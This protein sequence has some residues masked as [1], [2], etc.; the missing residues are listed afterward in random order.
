M[1]YI[2]SFFRMNSISLSEIE[3]QLLFFSRESIKHLAL[4]SKCGIPISQKILKKNFS[5]NDY[6]IIK[7]LN[8]IM[9]IYKKAKPNIYYSKHS[10]TWDDTTFKKELLVSS[11]ALM[12]LSI[13]KLATHYKNFKNIDDSLFELSKTYTKIA[14]IQLD[15]YYENLRNSEGFFVNKKSLSISNNSYPDLS[16]K[17]ATFSFSDQGYMMLAYYMYSKI[18]EDIKEAETFRSFSLE[19]LEMFD[20][21]K[22]FLYEESF[23]ECSQICYTLNIMYSISKNPKCKN[24][25]LDMSDFILSNYLDYGVSEKDISITTLTSL[26]LYLAY[27]NTNLLVFKEAFSDMCRSFKNLFNEDMLTF[28]KP[29]DKKDIK[30][31]NLELS[32]YLIN[33]MLYSKTTTDE[34][35]TKLLNELICNFYKETLVNSSLITSFP[36]APNLDSPERYKHF[37]CKSCDLLDDIMFTLPNVSTPGS[38]LLAPIYSKCINYSRKKNE[39]SNPRITFESFSNLFINF[40]VLDFF[41]DDYI[42]FICPIPRPKPFIPT[43]SSKKDKHSSKKSREFRTPLSDDT[44]IINNDTIDNERANTLIDTTI[45]K[46][47]NSLV[48]NS[49]FNNSTNTEITST[50]NAN[51]SEIK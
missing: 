15:F 37:S 12:T 7:E 25:L 13:L 46:E 29:G 5:S 39:F 17:S 44:D 42:K 32:L 35:E 48:N 3:S 49:T 30:Y 2:G 40:L 4:E 23:E 24:L 45:N 19:I 34:D 27:K 20:S 50:I 1:K 38:S 43:P 18:T 51:S 22:E 6:N 9:A 36:E 47:D 41:S 14:K 16:D 10:K 21:R 33:L 8:P 26:N 31:Y 11:N 28:I